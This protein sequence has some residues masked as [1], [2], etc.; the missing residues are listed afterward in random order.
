VILFLGVIA[1]T[2]YSLSRLAPGLVPPEDQ[3][4]ALVV[5]RL[6][7]T[8]SLQ[9]TIGVRD[10]LSARIGG[11][12]EVEQFTTFA[13]FDI[14][15]GSQRTNA[16]IGFANLTPW[17]E[18]TGPGQSAS[19]VI[20]QIFGVGATIPEANIFAFGLPP[21]QGLSLTGGVQG[22][23][24]FRGEATTDEIGALAQ[25][26][27]AAANARP[28]LANARTTLDTGVPRYLAEVDREKARAAD[29]PINAVFETMRST[30]GSLFVND[31]TLAGRNWQVNLQAEGEFRSQ[32]EDINQVFV[33]SRSGEMVALSSLV[34]LERVAGPDLIN[35][36]N[37]FPSAKFLADAAPGFTTGQAKQAAEEVAAGVLAGEDA[38]L[39]W[40][41][42]AYQLEATEGSGNVAFLLALLMVILILAAQ[43]ERWTLPLAVITAVPFGVLGAALAA[44]LRGF[45]NDIYF[46]VGLL[47]LIGLAAKNAILIVEFAAQNR[48]EGMSSFEAAQSAARQRFRAIL[49]TAFTFIIGSLP[50]VLSSGAGAAS[51]REIGTVV[52]GGML[53]AS[54]LALIFVP[55]AYKLFEDFSTWRRERKAARPATA[56]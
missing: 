23:L 8:A 2:G 55:L 39:E 34:E 40:T 37:V 3:G 7:P 31:F 47:V 25:Q 48:R 36:F 43:Y 5:Y 16:G 22:Y 44:L 49:M 24:Q 51:R 33:R 38:V 13:G 42:E 35:R 30:F 46:Q 21:I 17:S 6:P 56:R 32:P 18:R 27:A 29:V 19:A 52:V 4:A 54:S 53:L 11:I 9:R 12:P 45:P 41:G 10:E 14:V 26:L 50:L 1:G 28:E 20:G 15:A